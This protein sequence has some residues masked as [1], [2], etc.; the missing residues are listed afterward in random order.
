MEPLSQACVCVA[1]APTDSNPKSVRV[2]SDL[3]LESR[4]NAD[5]SACPYSAEYPPV[6]K[7]VPLNMNGR[8]LPRE[9]VL[10]PDGLYASITTMPSIN[11]RAS[12]PSPPRTNNLPL[13]P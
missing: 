13:S 4:T 8:N 9:G 11:V 3:S 7:L 6:L 2:T 10:G 12:L 5:E 1:S